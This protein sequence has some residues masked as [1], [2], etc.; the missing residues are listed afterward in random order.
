MPSVL[1]SITENAAVQH[2]L[3]LSKKATQSVGQEYT[4]VTFDLGVA[5]KAFSIVWQNHVKFGKVIVRTEVFHKI[6]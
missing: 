1:F 5:Q 2:V 6:C 4:I 3:E